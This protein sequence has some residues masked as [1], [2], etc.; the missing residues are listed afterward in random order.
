LTA[1]NRILL[2]IESTHYVFQDPQLIGVKSK[3]LP[4]FR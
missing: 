3:W 2:I 1:D 4:I